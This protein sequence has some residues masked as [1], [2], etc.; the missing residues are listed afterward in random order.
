MFGETVGETYE[1]NFTDMI[2]L[3][4]VGNFRI[5][6]EDLPDISIIDLNIK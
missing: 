5:N 6:T 1:N 2:P 3:V 4:T